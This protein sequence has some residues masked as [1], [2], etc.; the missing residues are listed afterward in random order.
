MMDY[1]SEFL[2]ELEYVKNYSSNTISSYNS[3]L[4]LFDSFIKK[5]LSKVQTEDIRKF[6]KR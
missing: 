1:I 2:I 3:D 4:L 5:D 6:I